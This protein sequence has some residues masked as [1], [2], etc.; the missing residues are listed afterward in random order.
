[1]RGSLE[2]AGTPLVVVEDFAEAVAEAGRRAGGG[3]VVVTGS[4]HTVGGAMT[5]LGVD[6]LD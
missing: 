5:V 2:T 6:P 4:V 1:V 3:T